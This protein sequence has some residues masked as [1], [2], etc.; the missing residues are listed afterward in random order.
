MF[1]NSVSAGPHSPNHTGMSCYSATDWS[2]AQKWAEFEQTSGKILIFEWP[3]G[4]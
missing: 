2:P 1:I 4:T 3:V